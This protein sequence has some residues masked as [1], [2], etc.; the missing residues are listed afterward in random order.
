VTNPPAPSRR[1]G[2]SPQPP[3]ALQRSGKGGPLLLLDQTLLPVDDVV[4]ELGRADAVAEAIRSLR[5]RGAPAIGLAAA[6]GL[7]L[8]AEW[9]AGGRM[10]EEE[11]TRE[12]EAASSLLRA[13]RPTGFNLAVCLDAMEAILRGTVG[14]PLPERVAALAAEAHRLHAEDEARCLRI[15]V[16]GQSVLPPAGG[17]ILTH[18]NAGA[19]A[20]GGIGTALAPIYLGHE[21]GRG[22]EVLAC[23]AR[24]VLQGSRLTAWELRRVG[25]PVTLIPDGAAGAAMAAGRVDLVI[26]GADRIA[27]NGDTANK[28]GTYGLAVLAAR[29]GIPF[30]VAAP[31]STLD[32]SLPHGR[33]IPIEERDPDEIRRGLGRITAPLD[34]PVWNPSFDVTP[35]HL[36]TSFITDAGILRPP[37]API[38]SQW[39][40]R[41][42]GVRDST[43]SPRSGP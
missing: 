25:V 40:T 34:V 16:A 37:F 23:E 7:A 18:C 27:A 12:V 13:T 20:T 11:W 10:D 43:R 33:A 9:L 2:P 22:V 28:I 35:A 32:L 39:G 19:L 5:V 21:Q 4:L 15:G 24:P 36:I 17:R 1:S 30:Y 26:V 6:H 14:Q 41:G 3:R 31:S 8:E 29:H 42:S 38:L